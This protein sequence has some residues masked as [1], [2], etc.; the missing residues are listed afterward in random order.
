MDNLNILLKYLVNS[1][2]VTRIAHAAGVEED[3]VE[4]TCV[5]VFDTLIPT[6][7]TRQEGSHLE[8][9]DLNAITSNFNKLLEGNSLK[10]IISDVALDKAVEQAKVAVVVKEILVNIRGRLQYMTAAKKKPAPAPKPEPVREEPKAEP[11]RVQTKVLEEA[12]EEVA[13]IKRPVRR[14]KVEELDDAMEETWEKPEEPAK[15]KRPVRNKPR[16]FEPGREAEGCESGL[17][18]EFESDEEELS[19]GEKIALYVVGALLIAVIVVIVVILL[20]IKG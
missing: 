16:R 1:D 11:V 19:K 14:S 13:E 2:D 12:E 6:D 4:K 9:K 15:I 7:F 5:L 20:K 18:S 3:V 8:K 17:E 10:K